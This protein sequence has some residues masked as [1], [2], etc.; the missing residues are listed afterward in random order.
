MTGAIPDDLPYGR[1]GLLGIRWEVARK[2]AIAYFKEMNRDWA[3]TG[4]GV[5]ATNVASVSVWSLTSSGTGGGAEDARGRALAAR[6]L[7]GR[8]GGEEARSVWQREIHALGIS[9]A[10]SKRSAGIMQETPERVLSRQV[11][12]WSGPPSRAGQGGSTV[13]G[14]PRS[15]S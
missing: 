9:M 7:Q 12:W 13:A 15:H 3:E 14:P 10:L 8:E 11:G 5:T 6:S 4:E 1:R 2:E